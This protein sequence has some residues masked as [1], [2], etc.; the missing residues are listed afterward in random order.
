MKPVEFC[1]RLD[2]TA[3]STKGVFLLTE[4]KNHYFVLGNFLS[5]HI[6]DEK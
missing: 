4:L 3:L 2:S 6:P 1:V 5:Q